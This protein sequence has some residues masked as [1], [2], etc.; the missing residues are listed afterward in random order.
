MKG[1]RTEEELTETISA[2]DA[3]VG[4]GICMDNK[5][6]D[7]Y[8]DERNADSRSI[9]RNKEKI[10]DI[11]GG[12]QLHIEEDEVFISE[13]VDCGY[14]S[15]Q[16][17]IGCINFYEMKKKVLKIQTIPVVDYVY[18]T[19]KWTTFKGVG[20]CVFTRFLNEYKAI[21]LYAFHKKAAPVLIKTIELSKDVRTV[22]DFQFF[23]EGDS[24]EVTC[25]YKEAL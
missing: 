2:D 18:F 17:F 19:H 1:D 3:I 9:W 21:T 22:N 14:D 13:P 7:I 8:Y 20:I 25:R 16:K 11:E 24:L 23:L 12:Y 6:G 15:N 10:L 4:S 5:T